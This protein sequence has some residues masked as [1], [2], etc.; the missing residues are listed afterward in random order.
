[1]IDY[2]ALHEWLIGI[3][4]GDVGLAQA[5]DFGYDWTENIINVS[6]RAPYEDIFPQ[7]LYEYFDVTAKLPIAVFAFL[8]E[9][10]HVVTFN[11]FD[12]NE[13]FASFIH[14]MF[15]EDIDDEAAFQ[16]AYWLEPTEFAANGWAAYF[17]HS[18]FFKVEE[19]IT[20][21]NGEK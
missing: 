3:G 15:L 21:F 14:K 13:L 12:D 16:N 6:D 5:D 20:I 18:H 8:H 10:G 4:L 9:V 2:R 17:I 1:M 7:F 11:E 19:L